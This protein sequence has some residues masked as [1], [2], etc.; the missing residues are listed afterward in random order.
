MAENSN[1]CTSQ[2]RLDWFICDIYMH[3]ASS[4]RAIDRS[5]ILQQAT[6][7]I[8]HDSKKS[9]TSNWAWRQRR[10]L[11]REVDSLY[12]SSRK[13]NP[14]TPQ[15]RYNLYAPSTSRTLT[16]IK[17]KT[18]DFFSQVVRR[19]WSFIARLSFAFSIKYYYLSIWNLIESE[20]SCKCNSTRYYSFMRSVIINFECNAYTAQIS[21]IWGH[22]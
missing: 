1:V 13:L 17:N 15:N 19:Q 7:E 21:V 16:R 3:S 22:Q 14:H 20:L 11:D 9:L 5:I 4:E 18:W 2:K 12:D 8:N 6:I 10:L